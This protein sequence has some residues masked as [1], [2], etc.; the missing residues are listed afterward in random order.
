VLTF[1]NLWPLSEQLFSQFL[2]RMS[3]DTERL[4]NTQNLEQKGELTLLGIG[5][6]FNDLLGQVTRCVRGKE[7]G[8]GLGRRLNVGWKGYVGAHPE[9][10]DSESQ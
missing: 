7:I 2:I 10:A 3:L 4:S 9:L 6:L 1:V 5:V 8:E